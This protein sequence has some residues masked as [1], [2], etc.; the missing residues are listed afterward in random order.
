MKT[1]I[2]SKGCEWCKT[3]GYVVVMVM[4]DGKFTPQTTPCYMCAGTGKIPVTEK[5]E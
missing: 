4:K 1:R 3:S 5:E 2:Y